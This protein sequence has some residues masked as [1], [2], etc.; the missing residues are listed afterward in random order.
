MSALLKRQ[1]RPVGTALQKLD[2]KSPNRAQ[3]VQVA[4]TSTAIVLAHVIKLQREV[5][6]EGVI[7]ANGRAV[8]DPIMQAPVVKKLIREKPG[9]LLL[10][11][12]EWSL[13]SHA[14][15][16]APRIDLRIASAPLKPVAIE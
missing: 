13:E 7:R 5:L 10:A 15:A 3:D 11:N 8:P 16:V 12:R 9:E 1:S 14:I 4:G 2:L 6:V